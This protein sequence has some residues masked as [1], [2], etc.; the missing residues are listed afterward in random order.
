MI[1]T[2]T[3]HHHVSQTRR[4]ALASMTRQQ[5]QEGTVTWL[6]RWLRT[7]GIVPEQRTRVS[8]LRARVEELRGAAA[9][10]EQVPVV[11]A[12]NP[13]PWR[14]TPRAKTI[15]NSRVVRLSYPHLTPTCS[16]DETSFIFKGGCWRTAEKLQ[17]F[18]VV[19]VPS[20]R[21]FVRP[22]RT[23]LR[24]IVLGLRI[25][26]G[27]TYSVNGLRRLGLR[28]GCHALAKGDID[29]AKKLII[30]GL[31]MLEGCCPVRKLVPALHCLI[32][33]ADEAKQH[34]VLRWFWMMCFGK[35]HTTTPHYTTQVV[36]SHTTTPPSR[37]LQ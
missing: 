8:D 28:Q 34:G 30:E 35:P 31:S 21:G 14:L 33:Y 12:L 36:S 10:G 24:N 3:Y 29:R 6:R 32:H 7:C 13:L 15:I 1:N 20:L 27:Q 23:S 9:R 11:G 37:A 18:L 26:E 2:N 4:R 16:V 25:L 19:L 22:V 17:A 5:I